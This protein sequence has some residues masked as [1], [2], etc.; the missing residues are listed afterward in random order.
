MNRYFRNT[1]IQVKVEVTYGTNP[2][3]WAATDCLLISDAKFEIDRDLVPRNLIRG[4]MGG[5]DQLVG[6]RRSNITFTVELA[7]AGAAG[8]APAWGKLLRMCGMAEAITALSR[9]EYT[10]VST[11]FTSATI[12]YFIDGV[13]YV[14]VGAR[15]TAKFM[16]N[17]YDRPVIEFTMQGF[18][19]N[20]T[21]LSL[22]SPT[23]TA[24]QRPQVVT[25]ANSGDI[26]LGGSYSAGAITI[27]GGSTLKSKGIEIDLGNK[28]SHMKMLGGESIDIVDREATGKMSVELTAAQEVTWRT[29]INANTL[30]T[31]A[32]RHGSA[33]GNQIIVFAPAVQRVTP[34]ME[35]YEGG[36]LMSTELRLLPS[37]GNDELMVVVK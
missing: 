3:S 30:S 8:T 28:V 22:P 18:D 15:G 31:L 7:G 19:T 35:D 27:G 12:R 25:D 6:T 29:D 10:P 37:A 13:M 24:W 1:V 5:S 26:I 11:A 2:G 20:A 17:A 4:F 34:Q 16:L 14:S 33:A 36:V 21:E 9:V 23:L 32:F